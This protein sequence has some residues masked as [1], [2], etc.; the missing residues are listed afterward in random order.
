MFKS[1]LRSLAVLRCVTL[2]RLH[3]RPIEPDDL[4]FRHGDRALP[5]PT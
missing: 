1:R 3:N 2:R 5:N 4:E